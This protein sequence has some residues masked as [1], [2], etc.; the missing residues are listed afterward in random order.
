[1]QSICCMCVLEWSIFT[2]LIKN[3]ALNK[4]LRSCQTWWNKEN[5]SNLW[6]TLLLLFQLAGLRLAYANINPILIHSMCI[7]D[8]EN[9]PCYTIIITQLFSQ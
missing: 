5:F 3:T 9:I 2:K 1:M 7:S 6:F 8:M 4:G